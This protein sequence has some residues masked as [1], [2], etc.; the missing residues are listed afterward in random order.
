M[1]VIAKDICQWTSPYMFA[2][3]YTM[4]YNPYT[5]TECS[6][7][8]GFNENKNG[9]VFFQFKGKKPLCVLCAC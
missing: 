9:C 8:Q 4:H 2:I 1:R 6:K 7:S 5:C 3:L